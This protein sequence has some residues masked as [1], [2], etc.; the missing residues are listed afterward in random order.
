MRADMIKHL[1]FIQAVINRMAA[2]SFLL[3]GWAITLA[4]AGFALA[5]QQSTPRYILAVVLVATVIL[6]WLDAYYLRQERLFRRLYDAVRLAS[7]HEWETQPHGR[8]SM[9]AQLYAN[10]VPSW[11]RAL[12][13]PTIWPLYG[14]IITGTVVGAIAL[15]LRN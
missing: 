13:A 2:N 1:E 8:F 15:S 14:I 7:E 3:K 9:E 11:L 12:W 6:W 4:A 5:A 10:A